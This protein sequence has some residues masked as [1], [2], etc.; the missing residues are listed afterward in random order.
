MGHLRQSE[1]SVPIFWAS[2]PCQEW[3]SWKTWRWYSRKH[4]K[5]WGA[6]IGTFPPVWLWALDLDDF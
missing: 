6:G 2:C 5:A 1:V 4:S 3:A